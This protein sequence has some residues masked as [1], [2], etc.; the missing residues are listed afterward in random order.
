MQILPANAARVACAIAGDAVAEAVDPGQLLG[1]DVQEL[2]GP[3]A[4]IAQNRG[5]GF[6]AREPA[7]AVAAQHGA[8]GRDR[9]AYAAVSPAS[10]QK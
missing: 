4:L 2:A 3:L 6:E 7:E 10:G 9:Q 5:L 8:H 1:V